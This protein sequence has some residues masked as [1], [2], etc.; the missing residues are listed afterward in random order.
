MGIASRM[1]LRLFV[2]NSL[3]DTCI[4]IIKIKSFAFKLSMEVEE[5]EVLKGR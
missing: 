3:K 1:R 2:I 4:A 5:M